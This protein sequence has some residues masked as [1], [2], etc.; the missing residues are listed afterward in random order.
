L[1]TSFQLLSTSVKIEIFANFYRSQKKIYTPGAY[2]SGPLLELALQDFNVLQ[3]QLTLEPVMT[4]P[5][6]DQQYALIT[7]AA[8]SMADIRHHPDPSRQGGE[9]LCHLFRVSTA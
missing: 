7:D 8:A 6:A 3:K 5:K 9:L 4:F 1:H 2:K